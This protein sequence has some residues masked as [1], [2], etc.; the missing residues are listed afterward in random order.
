MNTDR[1]AVMFFFL[2]VTFILLWS[3]AVLSHTV[4]DTEGKTI[5]FSRPFSRIISLYPAHTENLLH[6]H[7]NDQIIGISVSDDKKASFETY[8]RFSYRDDPERFIAIQPDLVLIRPMISKVYPALLEQ[9]DKAGIP[10][11]S[12]QPR[13][14]EEMFHYW[15]IL[16]KLTGKATEAGQMVVQFKKGLQTMKNRLDKVPPEERPL[17]Y[18]ESIHSRMK[19]FAPTSMAMFCLE[20]AGGRNIASDAVPRLQSNIAS[21]GKEKLLSR[22]DEIEVFLA[23]KGRMNQVSLDIIRNEPGF[24][25]IKAVRTN[26]IYLIDEKLVSR[27]TPKLLS[28]I[29]KIH[30]QLFPQ[31]LTHN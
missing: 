21:Y 9:L 20:H 19:T 3:D 31:Q 16:G 1:L 29:E 15:L 28:G 14:I 23:Q 8:K 30:Q 27:P 24:R 22:G 26:R 17:V 4:T 13:S 12:L 25:A 5:E 7:A 10:Y 18:F 6:L 11:L 2:P